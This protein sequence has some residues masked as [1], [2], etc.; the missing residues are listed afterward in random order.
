MVYL[1]LL[2]T[3]DFSVWI[4]CECAGVSHDPLCAGHLFGLIVQVCLITL[5]LLDTCLDVQVFLVTLCFLDN[6]IFLFGLIVQVCL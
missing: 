6:L 4:D 5:H 1:R 3:L 2:D